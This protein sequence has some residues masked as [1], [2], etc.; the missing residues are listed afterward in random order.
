[1]RITR[2]AIV[3]CLMITMAA[4]SSSNSNNVTEPTGNPATPSTQQPA[5]DDSSSS[6]KIKITKEQYAQ[7]NNGMTYKEVAEIVGGE[8]EVIT[9]SGE[10]GSDMY[11]IGVMYEGEGGVGASANFIF[12]GDKLQTKTQ[13]GL[14]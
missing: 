5:N 6:D 1:M 2:L 14:E 8:G 3:I 12:I 11:G 4:C 10:K 7:I 13:F 9:E